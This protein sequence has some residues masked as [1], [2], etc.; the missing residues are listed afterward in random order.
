MKTHRGPA[1][2]IGLRSQIV[3]PH[4]DVAALMDAVDAERLRREHSLTRDIHGHRQRYPW[5]RVA[6]ESGISEA[7][8]NQLPAAARAPSADT[9]VR[10]LVWLGSADLR[11]F[12]A[13]GQTDSA[14]PVASPVE[15]GPAHDPPPSPS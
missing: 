7:T 4:L 6:R 3:G 11:P 8:M 9:L 15:R 13:Y 14:L 1:G 5:T 12:I 2:Y 10:L